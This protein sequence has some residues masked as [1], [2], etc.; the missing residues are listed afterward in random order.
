MSAPEN[1]SWSENHSHT[2]SAAASSQTPRKIDH[3][4]S[5]KN[6][7]SSASHPW[8]VPAGARLRTTSWYT[9]PSTNRS[10]CQR[11]RA[12]SSGS[13][14]HHQIGA[15]EKALGGSA[16]TAARRGGSVTVIPSVRWRSRG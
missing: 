3:H 2:P 11:N 9:P 4:R 12:G 8:S 13:P 10:S 16:R 5:E 14:L 1:P 6:G 15:G 7:G